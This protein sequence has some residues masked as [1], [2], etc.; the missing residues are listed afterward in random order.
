MNKLLIYGYITGM[1]IGLACADMPNWWYKLIPISIGAII[2]TIIDCITV[3]GDK[4]E[5]N[6]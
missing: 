4:N 1:F 5:E 6:I 2:I 3:E